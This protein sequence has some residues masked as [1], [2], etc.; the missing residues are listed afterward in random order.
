MIRVPCLLAALCVLAAPGAAGAQD[1]GAPPLDPTPVIIDARAA[2]TVDI[3]AGRIGERQTR[4]GTARQTGVEPMARIQNRVANRVQ[5]RLRT[6]IDRTYD[7][8]A[9]ATSPFAVASDQVRAVGRP[10][11][12]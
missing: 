2:R 9:H 11:R 5:S 7:P 8:R 1:R 3:G 4:E 12:R 6:R 10:R